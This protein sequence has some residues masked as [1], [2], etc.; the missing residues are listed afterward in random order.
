[1]YDQAGEIRLHLC[2]VITRHFNEVCVARLQ[3]PRKFA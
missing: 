3:R 2:V 1:M